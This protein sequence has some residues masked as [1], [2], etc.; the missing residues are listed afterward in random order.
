MKNLK[1]VV[2]LMSLVLSFNTFS[3][4]EL[5]ENENEKIKV[6]SVDVFGAV[7]MDCFKYSTEVNGEK[8]IKYLFTYQNLK[9]STITD[10]KSFWINGDKDF[11]ELYEL[12]TETIGKEEKNIEIKLKSGNEL[13]LKFNKKYV[14]FRVWNGTYWS[15]SPLLKQK[16]IDKLFGKYIN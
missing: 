16:Q 14:Q 10:Y 13:T 4:L 12:I 2:L 6:G 15:F 9:Y 11:N 8:T 1:T 5:I 7:W 3:Q